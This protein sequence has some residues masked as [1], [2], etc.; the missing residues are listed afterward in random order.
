MTVD[1]TIE[2]QPIS[3]AAPPR[4]SLPARA[5]GLVTAPRQVFEE[6]REQP[7]WVVPA[8]ILAS[9][10]GIMSWF[11]YDPLLYPMMIERID[12]Q[13]LAPD[14][15]ARAEEM[16]ASPMIKMFTILT[17][18]V[19]TFGMIPAFGLILFAAC[20]FLL[21]GRATA[22][23][24]ISVAAHACL[25]LIPRS[26]LLLPLLFAR[27]DPTLSLGPGVLMPPSEAEGFV[28]RFV[29]NFLSGALDL[30]HLWALGLAIVGM[31]VMSRL[32]TRTVA[33]ALIAF[34]LGIGILFALFGTFGR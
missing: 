15:A 31:S 8:L 10:T 20:S 29:A 32:A 25:V 1:P 21:G 4:R 19:F 11:I 27:Q 24:S 14:Q 6:L 2:T 23:Q 26:L 28:G 30:F 17:G 5:I 22:R 9:F 12:S 33:V 34:Y 16:Y 7:S 13:N 3:A 18:A